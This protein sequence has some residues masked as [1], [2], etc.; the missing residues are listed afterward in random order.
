MGLDG[1]SERIY[2]RVM[3]FYLLAAKALSEHARGC[4]FPH[5]PAGSFARCGFFS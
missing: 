4:A 5:H 3:Y 1:F 2:L